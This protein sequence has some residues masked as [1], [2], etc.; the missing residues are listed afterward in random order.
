[1]GGDHGYGRKGSLLIW[2]S[3]NE[4]D[5]G[6]VIEDEQIRFPIRCVLVG[7]GGGNTMNVVHNK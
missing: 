3:C 5:S 4:L 7:G 2:A 1:M 6:L